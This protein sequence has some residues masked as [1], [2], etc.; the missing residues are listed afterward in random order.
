M[1]DKQN[2]LTELNVGFTTE[3]IAEF[4]N[5]IKTRI[6]YNLGQ[7]E[8]NIRDLMFIDCPGAQGRVDRIKRFNTGKPNL[9]DTIVMGM[10]LEVLGLSK[11]DVIKTPFNQ[12]AKYFNEVMSILNNY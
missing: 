2:P 7:F 4:G 3:L 10:V 1:S 11:S 8:Y 6:E 5:N 12:T 9:Y